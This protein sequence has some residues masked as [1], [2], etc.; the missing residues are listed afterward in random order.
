M[1]ATIYSNDFNRVI[2]ATKAFVSKDTT[3]KFRR[4]IRLE[5]SASDSRMTAMAVDG[6]RM[7]VEH[8]VCECDEDFVT[9]IHGSIKLPR[10]MNARIEVT[11]TETLIRCGDFIFGCPKITGE[12]DFDWRLVLPKE[13]NF[14]IGFNGN[15]LITALQA[16][17]VSC[18]DS[19]KQPVILEFRSPSEPIVLRTNTDDF[20]LVLP[21][22]IGGTRPADEQ[23]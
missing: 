23:K 20:K 13:S 5:F 6:C 16:A 2:A 9:Y 18:G 4:Y 3:R 15:Y 12:D 19:F 8:S 11:G 21:V 7:S 17:K 22:R 14:Q 10:K 1:K